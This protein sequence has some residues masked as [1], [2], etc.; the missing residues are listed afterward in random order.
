MP[1]RTDTPIA[2]TRHTVDTITDPILTALYDEREQ[3]LAAIARARAAIQNTADDIAEEI[4]ATTDPAVS[5]RLRGAM[6]RVLHI[7]AALNEPKEPTT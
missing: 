3:F 5:E 4:A 6:Q 7:R 2:L 1:D